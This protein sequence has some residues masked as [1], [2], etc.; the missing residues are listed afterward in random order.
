MFRVEPGQG[1][2]R[3]FESLHTS[4]HPTFRRGLFFFRRGFSRLSVPNPFRFRKV[5]GWYLDLFF[6]KPVFGARR[7]RMPRARSN[8][9]GGIE[10]VSGE[11]RLLVPSDRHRSS[12]L[13]VGTLRHTGKKRMRNV[14]QVAVS[15][16]G[17]SGLACRSCAT[18]TRRRRA[19]HDAAPPLFDF[20]GGTAEQLAPGGGT[21]DTGL[22][23]FF[24]PGEQRLERV[25]GEPA[26]GPA[27]LHSGNCN[28][29]RPAFIFFPS[30]NAGCTAHLA[31]LHGDTFDLRAHFRLPFVQR[32]FD[33]V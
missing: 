30:I 17:R 8:R 24:F 33:L 20:E 13:A 2:P 6:K 31:Y 7:R 18:S 4:F 10:T 15:P 3:S 1:P 9:E 22:V 16:I 32:Y 12:A 11:T 21:R 19:R 25:K 28:I 29:M 23:V 27:N 26:S 5:P 14:P